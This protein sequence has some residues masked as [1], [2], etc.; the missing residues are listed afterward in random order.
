[1]KEILHHLGWLKTYKQ[2]DVYHLSIGD[3]DFAT[4][5][6][7]VSESIT[8]FDPSAHVFLEILTHPNLQRGNAFH[9]E[10]ARFGSQLDPSQ[11]SKHG[12]VE[13][14]FLSLPNAEWKGS[15]FWVGTNVP[16]V[17]ACLIVSVP[18]VPGTNPN[19]H[20]QG[21]VSCRLCYS[22]PLYLAV[23]MKHVA[24]RRTLVERSWEPIRVMWLKQ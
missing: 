23:Q 5:H 10:A 17:A 20:I 18:D 21:A 11:R 9:A 12:S 16:V 4:I 24:G 3:S 7:M 1:M 15:V 8:G 2:W 14:F 6:R 22:L 13:T 19:S